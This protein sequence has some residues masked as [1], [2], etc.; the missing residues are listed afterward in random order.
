MLAQL[1]HELVHVV[2]DQP[3]V[4]LLG[5]EH[6]QV[7]AGTGL[8]D[9]EQAAVE[10]GHGLA[11]APATVAELHRGALRQAL[12][13]GG[14]GGEVVSAVAAEAEAVAELETVPGE[15]QCVTGSGGAFQEVFEEP[16]ELVEVHHSSFGLPVGS[17]PRTAE[18][19]APKRRAEVA[20]PEV[21]GP[22][23]GRW[24]AGPGSG[25]WVAARV[26]PRLRMGR[27]LAW[28]GGMSVSSLSGRPTGSGPVPAC[29][30]GRGGGSCR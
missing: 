27:P 1:L 15:H 5:G 3:R 4:G 25:R 26:R 12:E 22:D 20:G 11:H 9:E 17:W 14:D 30:A 13:S 21:A 29:G 2:S 7:G 28:R 6:G 23:S 16:G 24:V 10:L 18:R 19:K 8:D